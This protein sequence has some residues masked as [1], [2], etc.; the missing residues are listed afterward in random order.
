MADEA[1]TLPV[2]QRP[3]MSI[4]VSNDVVRNEILEVACGDRA[5]IHGAVVGGLRVRQNDNHLVSALR[6]GAFNCLGHV[7]LVGPL[8]RAD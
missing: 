6:E 5:R 2:R 1:A 4:D 7:Y 3:V 8:L